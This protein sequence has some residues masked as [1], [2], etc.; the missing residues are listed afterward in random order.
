MKNIM[1]TAVTNLTQAEN[2]K[3]SNFLSNFSANFSNMN[4]ILGEL[5]TVLDHELV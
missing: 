3:L 5:Q 1:A 4:E 2:E